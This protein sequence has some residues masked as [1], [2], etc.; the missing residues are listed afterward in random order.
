MTK[1]EGIRDDW[2]SEV[3]MRKAERESG[4]KN[5]ESG[6]RKS[7][8]KL[9]WE[10]GKVRRWEKKKSNM[11]VGNGNGSAWSKGHSA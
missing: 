9:I 1:G 4:I 3:G 5:S 11:E 6:M 10:A 7:E 2:N 8:K